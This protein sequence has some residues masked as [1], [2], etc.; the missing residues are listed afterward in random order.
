MRSMELFQ[1]L[2]PIFTEYGYVAVFSM[3]LICGFG[4]PVPED[5]TLVTGGVIAGLGH[6]NQHVMLLVGMAGVL[7]GDGT[8]FGLGRAYGQRISRFPG[9]CR[10]LTEQRFS[11][12]QAAFH[13]YG[14]W[15]MFVSRFLP[16]L[17][18]PMFF[19]AGMSH[20]VS[21]GTWFAMDGL[22][23]LISVPIWVYLGYFGAQNWEWLF[24]VLRQFQHGILALL[25]GGGMY[26][27]WRWWQGRL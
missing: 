18:T 24:G 26:L 15:V 5:V 20:R 7:V 12:A 27:A 14:K 21:A 22:A 25:G 19:S 17:R 13:R 10:V 9:F 23:A 6:A 16:G 1:F 4:V 3:L 8:M 2:I 11:S